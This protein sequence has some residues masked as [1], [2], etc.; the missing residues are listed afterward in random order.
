VDKL[1]GQV[2]MLI[3]LPQ[4]YDTRGLA[5]GLAPQDCESF[6]LT[7]E[8]YALWNEMFVSNGS[9]PERLLLDGVCLSGPNGVG[10]SSVLHM[11]A[12]LA[13]FNDWI[14]LY[15]PRALQWAE[16]EMGLD[17]KPSAEPA[18]RYFLKKFVELNQVYAEELERL[19]PGLWNVIEAALKRETSAT[20]AQTDLMTTL[21]EQY[22]Y[23]VLYAFDEHQVLF[24]K[25]G[26]DPALAPLTM[27]PDYFRTFTSWQG[28]TAGLRT[29]TIYSGSAHSKFEQGLASGEERRLR[30]IRPW[31]LKDFETVT[32]SP[33]S[34]L[35]IPDLDRCPEEEQ[36][37]REVTG[38]V[39]RYIRFVKDE[40]TAIAASERHRSAAQK[41]RTAVE[42]VEN[43]TKTQCEAEIEKTFLGLRMEK[44]NDFIDYLG[45]ILLP[46]WYG[47]LPVERNSQLYDKGF[48]FQDED[49]ALEIPVLRPVNGPA[50]QTLLRFFLQ[51]T[52]DIEPVDLRM[53]SAG[54]DFQRA[55]VRAAL[56]G[57][58][59]MFHG[60]YYRQDDDKPHVMFN[61]SATDAIMVRNDF[62]L[63]HESLLSY[64][65][66]KG[67][68]VIIIPE[69]KSFKAWDF[70][71]YSVSRTSATTDDKT[72]KT[73]TTTKRTVTFVQTTISEG[74]PTASGHWTVDFKHANAMMKSV[75][76][77]GVVSKVLQALGVDCSKIEYDEDTDCFQIT[78]RNKEDAVQFV[79]VT[80]CP[81]P[82]R[83]GQPDGTTIKY[84]FQN[85]VVV[86]RSDV[87]Q[88]GIVFKE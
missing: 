64:L 62:S 42:I 29:Y 49:P 27:R 33:E 15:I 54:Y 11:L 34:S 47:G 51:Q 16:V 30:Y 22:K 31:K 43:R 17:G 84:N 60:R 8:R 7:E 67:G 20:I 83:T 38:H 28:E 53:E 14:V 23:S 18:A 81:L 36:Y 41:I 66:I 48:I 78:P 52:P 77:D 72:A 61:L 58:A 32:R 25:A 45:H 37:M 70:I 80:S 3:K 88:W 5:K 76:S 26:E 59:N 6:L 56:Q 50:R 86:H 2:G 69:S 85:L 24:P 4:L 68:N 55:V 57:R 63:S 82:T 73:T 79:L 21:G 40:H 65:H 87:E 75:A 12:S 46:A 13:H 44:R 9:Y 10:K 1:Q 39:P 74:K 71:H 19:Q 35:Y